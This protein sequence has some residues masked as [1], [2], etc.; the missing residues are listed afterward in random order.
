MFIEHCSAS[1]RL[2]WIEETYSQG[3]YCTTAQLDEVPNLI[4]QGCK[5][6]QK[7]G[8]HTG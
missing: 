8:S 7:G 1:A 2:Q 4:S 6:N 3:T 5:P